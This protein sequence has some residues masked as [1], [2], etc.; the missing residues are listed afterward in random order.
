[1]AFALHAAE[2]VN[3]NEPVSYIDAKSRYDWNDWNNAMHE[4]MD[5]LIKNNTRKLVPK[6]KNKKIIGCK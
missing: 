1:M 5:S 4:E 6:P 3:V 2:V